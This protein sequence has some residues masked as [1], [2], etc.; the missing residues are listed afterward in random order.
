MP[1]NQI[2]KG[3]TFVTGQLVTA[4]NLN[5][6]AQEATLKKGA[7]SEQPDMAT[8]KNG[9]YNY[10]TGTSLTIAITA[11][12]FAL[13][14]NVRIVF[15]NTSGAS[16]AFFDNV[17]TVTAVP[18]ADTFNIVLQ[19]SYDPSAGT[20][21]ARLVPSP[22]D[23]LLI[24]DVS[25]SV[26]VR[27]KRITLGD[28]TSSVVNASFS[29]VSTNTLTANTSS[30]LMLVA[31]DGVLVSGATYSSIDG[32]SVVVTK[33]SHG[34]SAGTVIEI[35]CTNTQGNTGSA[36]S[37]LYLIEAATALTFTYYLKD[38]AYI[39]IDEN[40]TGEYDQPLTSSGTA[41]YRKIGTVNMDGEVVVG[42]DIFINGTTYNRGDTF[43]YGRA[44]FSE[45][46][47]PKGRTLFRPQSPEEGQLFY[48][49]DD[50]IVEIFRK[51]LAF[52]AGSWE[53]FDKVSN[54]I[55]IPASYSQQ[56]LIADTAST[57]YSKTV[58]TMATPVRYMQYEITLP[59]FRFY[60]LN[61]GN[62]GAVYGKIELIAKEAVNPEPAQEYVIARYVSNVPNFSP[63]DVYSG[64]VVGISPWNKI[65]TPDDIDMTNMRLTLRVSIWQQQ[66][67]VPT[68]DATWILP[69]VGYVRI[70]P[71]VRTNGVPIPTIYKKEQQVN[72]LTNIVQAQR[73]V[74]NWWTKKDATAY[75]GGVCPIP[76]FNISSP[77]NANSGQNNY[78]DATSHQRGI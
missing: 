59:Q 38:G 56:T 51:S 12:G 11:H 6:A 3:Y 50:D 35:T 41:T 73:D 1:N 33:S 77:G 30:G 48:N 65:I 25:D 69:S 43:T 14:D 47:L 18:S 29:D 24:H 22:S 19:E 21:A 55:I 23:Q 71:L 78:Y 46:V 13:N 75:P 52:P 4:D 60:H 67:V 64:T 31:D 63:W 58:W 66:T 54:Q 26:E 8:V 76:L 68:T 57:W 53:T 37:G 45:F 42:N 36:Y 27:P 49:R 20:V 17:Y 9:T 15:T 28:L 16:G 74:I 40:T 44:K 61:N 72:S 62:D 7:I 70:N 10:T 32:S 39:T 34:L 2:E 5:S